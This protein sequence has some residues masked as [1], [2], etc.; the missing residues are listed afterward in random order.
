MWIGTWIWN[1]SAKTG[2]PVSRTREW[3]FLVKFRES[4]GLFGN[5]TWEWGPELCARLP[6]FVWKSFWDLFSGGSAPLGKGRP[7][8]PFSK[9]GVKMCPN[10]K[11]SLPGGILG[12]NWRISILP[13]EAR[14][15]G[16]K[17]WE[18][19]NSVSPHRDWI[20]VNHPGMYYG[21]CSMRYLF[22]F[23][24]IIV[25]NTS[26]GEERTHRSLEHPDPCTHLP[27]AVLLVVWGGI[28]IY[29]TGFALRQRALCN[30]FITN[31]SNSYLK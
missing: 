3:G 9:L 27:A 17:M 5:H 6:L 11:F 25:L 31:Y 12:R 24:I 2:K 18:W 13:A 26:E 29:F 8:I 23:L 1:A 22:T 19:S 16:Q 14:P 30:P 15:D 20:I 7:S 28:C 10:N 4:K 21:L